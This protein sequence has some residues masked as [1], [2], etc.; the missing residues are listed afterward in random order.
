MAVSK[1]PKTRPTRIRVR[2]STPLAPMP[3]DAAK[4]DSPSDS[5]TSSRASMRPRY[6]ICRAGQGT[7][8]T[9]WSLPVSGQAASTSASGTDLVSTLS[10]PWLMAAARPESSATM[11]RVGTDP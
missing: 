5:A 4:L 6:V 11:S 10:A 2:A 3:T 1:N 8:T 7:M 9:R